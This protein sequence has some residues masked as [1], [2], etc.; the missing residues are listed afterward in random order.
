MTARETLTT[1]SPTA[2]SL[3]GRGILFPGDAGTTDVA[4]AGGKAAGLARLR[5]AGCNV[6]P[7]FV[8]EPNCA[9][10]EDALREALE[11]LADHHPDSHCHPELV[12]GCATTFAVRSSAVVEDGASASYAGQFT[13]VLFVPREGVLDAIRR[14]RA[15]AASDTVRAYRDGNGQFTAMAVIVQ[16]M[17]D[18]DASGVAFGIDPIGG[19][20]VVVVTAAYGL[21]SGVVDGDCTADAWRVARDGT[22]AG[23]TIAEKDRKHVRVPGSGTTTIAV[24]AA[25]RGRPALAD[26][27]VR[28][29]A[30][31]ARNIADAA[32][33]PQDVEF[34]FAAGRLWALQARPVTAVAADAAPVAVWDDSN[35]AESYGGIVGAL[36]YSFARQAYAGAYR[37]FFRLAGVPRA[38]IDAHARTFEALVGNI[39]GHMMYDLVGWYRMLAL[40][41]GYRLNRRLMEEMMGVREALPTE[42]AD[43]IAR[44][45]RRGRVRDALMLARTTLALTVT[46]V[47]LPRDI[48]RFHAHVD[49]TLAAGPTS[50]HTAHG[51]MSLVELVREYRRLERA[52]LDRWDVPIANDFFVMLSFGVLKRAAA[53]WCGDASLAPA[54]IAAGGEMT[55]AEPARAVRELAELDAAG[56]RLGFDLA[57][58]GY[59]ARFGDRCESELKLESATLHDDPRPLLAAI[60]RLRNAPPDDAHAATALHGDAE[61]RAQDALRGHP[62]RAFVF[63]R[64]VAW[65]RA[66]IVA[67]ENLRFERTRVF[68][69]VRR[70]VVAMGEALAQRGALGDARD[71]FHLTIDELLGYAEGTS[72]SRDLRGLAAVRRAESARYAAA[73]PPPNRFATRD[74]PV[75]PLAV[76]HATD[77]DDTVRTG[78]PCCAGVVR[79]RVR[80]VR[81]PCGTLCRGEILVAERTDPSW[82]VLFPA[83]AAIL[84]ERGSQLSHA[85]IVSREMAIPSVV[86]IRGLTAWLRDGDLVELDGATGVVRRIEAAP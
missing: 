12:E 49:A 83:A 2:E 33:A 63:A 84:V 74:L 43:A 47:R 48:A 73:P 50:R 71:V 68:G 9:P 70:I 45:C 22:I 25:L 86:A 54:L 14:V 64:L 77:G 1:E 59:L 10:D 13:S 34:T 30:S 31:L 76:P 72:A 81:E 6:P 85:A 24:D 8:I 60:A 4:R 51:D 26:A 58:N 78:T 3:A 55:S 32:G 36:T 37:A 39:D 56:D 79:A 42:L 11:R 69:A 29:V 67:R 52:L 40:L 46:A 20:D 18:G 35:I 16:V 7:W 17:V 27:D 23:R 15:S 19:S 44:D 61:S 53:A 28:A 41:P 80:V 38:E 21:A 65:A 5:D 82:V 75:A 62:L 66:R 57:F